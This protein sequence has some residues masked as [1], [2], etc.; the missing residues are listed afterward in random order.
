[1]R[2][3]ARP[4]RARRGWLPVV[5]FQ[6]DAEFEDA[7]VPEMVD[8]HGDGPQRVGGRR[9]VKR[10]RSLASAHVP[11]Q[12]KYYV[13]AFPTP[14]NTN[15]KPYAAETTN[16][17]QFRKTGCTYTNEVRARVLI[18]ELLC[19]CKKALISAQILSFRKK[20]MIVGSAA[21]AFD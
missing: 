1:M 3:P 2:R 12:V 14:R 19:S 7:G 16:Q 18:Q 20:T 21:T 15:N 5:V 11:K 9:F 10:R 17:R 6:V 8:E 13:N 4:G